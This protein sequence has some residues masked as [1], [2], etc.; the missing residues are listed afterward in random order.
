MFLPGKSP[1]RGAW[2]YSPSGHERVGHDLATDS[3]SHECRAVILPMMSC[4]LYLFSQ[5]WNSTSPS[6]CRFQ[7][8]LDSEE[9]SQVQLWPFSQLLFFSTSG[10]RLGL[11]LCLLSQPCFPLLYLPLYCSALCIEIFLVLFLPGRRLRAA[12]P[13][14]LELSCWMFPC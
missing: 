14:L 12:S 5:P 9:S 7:T 3:Q 1:D 6:A 10:T 8:F 2:G 4:R 13:H 11:L